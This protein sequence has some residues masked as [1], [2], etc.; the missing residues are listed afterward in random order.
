MT[1][2]IEVINMATVNKITRTI[3]SLSLAK[4]LVNNPG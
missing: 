3:R 4:F 1:N 2:V